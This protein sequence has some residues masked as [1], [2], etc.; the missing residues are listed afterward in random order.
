V[1]HLI[2][3]VLSPS[4]RDVDLEEKRPVYRAAGVR[5][6]WFV[7][8]EEEQILVDRRQGRRYITDV[9]STGEVS[10]RAL[11]GFRLDA[12]WLWTD[13]LPNVMQCLRDILG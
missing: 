6:I 8:H 11:A 13:P 1:P 3:E 9:V 10:S 4:N 7:D 2:L 5:E 12:A